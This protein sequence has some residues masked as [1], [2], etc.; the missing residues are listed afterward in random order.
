MK[1]LYIAVDFEGIRPEEI[2]EL[3]DDE[4]PSMLSNIHCLLLCSSM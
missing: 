2:A 4:M 1:T 3:D